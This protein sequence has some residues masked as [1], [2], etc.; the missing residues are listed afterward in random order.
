MKHIIKIDS[1]VVEVV[2][3]HRL[4][5][6]ESHILYKELIEQAFEIIVD[7]DGDVSIVDRVTKTLYK[8][9]VSLHDPEV[10][11]FVI[12]IFMTF[13]KSIVE[14][15]M[16]NSIHNFKIIDIRNENKIIIEDTK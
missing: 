5:P 2:R 14:Y 12:N 3:E 11:K 13:L 1:Y 10:A 16:V 9:C 4:T 7:I 15:L 8:N 6:A